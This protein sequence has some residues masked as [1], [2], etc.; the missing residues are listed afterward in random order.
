MFSFPVSGGFL[1]LSKPS[2][3]TFVC[4]LI[5]KSQLG[6]FMQ[7][8]NDH[9]DC[10]FAQLQWGLF[11]YFSWVNKK[12]MPKALS[13]SFRGTIFDFEI[14]EFNS[15]FIILSGPQIGF[16]CYCHCEFATIKTKWKLYFH[17]MKR[18]VVFMQ[19]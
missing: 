2:N 5:P 14:S 9:L 13:W 10:R 12:F 7:Y 6:Q 19:Y 3:T 18:R 15:H 8:I 17:G 16:K 4:N 1:F 11:T